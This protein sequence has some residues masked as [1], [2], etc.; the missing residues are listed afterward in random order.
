MIDLLVLSKGA[1][2]PSTRY[3]AIQYFEHFAAAGY[4]TEHRSLADGPGNYLAALDAAR[5]ADIVLVLRKTLPPPLLWVLRKVSRRLIFDLDDAIFCN[6]DGSSSA[7]RMSRFSAMA[8]VCDRVIAGNAFLAEVSGRYNNRVSIMPTA[9]DVARYRPEKRKP[10]DSFDVVWIGSSS[11]RKY[12][13]D[14]LPAL[15]LAASHIPGLRLKIIADFD[16]DAPGFPTLAVPWCAETE[17]AELASS[18]VGIAPMRDDDWS[19]GKCALKVL[20]YMAAGLPVVSSPVGVNREAVV[21]GESGFLVNDDA[22][23]VDALSALSNDG[24]LIVRMGRVGRERV[25][26]FYAKDVVA[27]ALLAVFGEILSETGG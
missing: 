18:H 15:R 17:V 10:E 23:W 4:R 2:S 25:E 24:D 20:Q 5:R 21:D 3:R 1:E 27:E 12:L 19:R 16:L 22:A 7:T 11:T 14:A 26:R 6:T 9:V 13:E 8:S